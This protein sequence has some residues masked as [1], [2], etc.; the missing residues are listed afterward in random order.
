MDDVKRILVVSRDT[1]YR[2]KLSIMG[3]LSLE[4]MG[5]NLMSFM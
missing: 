5:R 3:Y 1:K 4:N 2:R